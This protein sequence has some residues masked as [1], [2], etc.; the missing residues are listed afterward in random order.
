[1]PEEKLTKDEK[2]ALRKLAWEEKAQKEQRSASLKKYS[3][4]V[5]VV[6]IVILTIVGLFWL[7][8]APSPSQNQVVNVAPVSTRD[9]TKGNKNAPVT[10]IEYADF[11]CSACAVYHP[12][13]NK[14]LQT[15]SGKIFYVYRMFP[16]TNTHPNSRISAQAAYAAHKQGKFFEVS[17]ML[18]NKQDEWVSLE[19]PTTAFADYAKMLKLDINKFKKDLNS[20]ETKKYV[21]TSE[22]EALSE[23]LDATPTF[24]LNGKKI[25]NPSSLDDFKKL[26]DNELNKK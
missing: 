7:V 10:L 26:I 3:I 1:M 14:I 8:T 5:T 15:Y 4:W 9:I 16:L 25:T 23:G 12:L 13:V 17:D 2:K 11:Q 19:D 18:F 21:D 22:Q 20:D 24:I 6:V